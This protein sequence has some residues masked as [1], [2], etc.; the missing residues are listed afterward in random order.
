M[1]LLMQHA[2]TP[3]RPPSAR[4]GWPIPDALDRLVLACLAKDPT[5]RPQTAKDLARRLSEVDGADDWTEAR[6]RAWWTE[7]LPPVAVTPDSPPVGLG[8]TPSPQASGG[9]PSGSC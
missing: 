8:A 6:A 2:Q 3:P 4:A 9:R 1:A 5:A 7:H